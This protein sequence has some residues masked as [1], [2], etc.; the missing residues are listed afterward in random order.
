V[1]QREKAQQTGQDNEE[2]QGYI[3][4]RN[5]MANPRIHGA[6]ARGFLASSTAASDRQQR[7][8]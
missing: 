8:P 3:D 4:E 2:T 1:F 5:K 7:R 6:P